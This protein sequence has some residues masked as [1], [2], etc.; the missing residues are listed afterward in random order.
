MGDGK[1]SGG[2]FSRETILR[3]T[4]VER[5][6]FKSI[7]MLTT[8]SIMKG[9]RNVWDYDPIFLVTLCNKCHTE[10][11]SKNENHYLKPIGIRNMSVIR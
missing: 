11:H 7:F 8:F 10:W 3:A 2:K 5:R 4:N 6:N 9:D 1:L